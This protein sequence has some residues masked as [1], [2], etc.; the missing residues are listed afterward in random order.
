MV[1]ASQLRESTDISVGHMTRN[2]QNS[3]AG[4]HVTVSH[5]ESKKRFFSGKWASERCQFC[6]NGAV[7]SQRAPHI[8]SKQHHEH[9]LFLLCCWVA[10][11]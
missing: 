3:F 7:P 1:K 2:R 11:K 5:H 10:R 4:S 9:V 8:A 6:V